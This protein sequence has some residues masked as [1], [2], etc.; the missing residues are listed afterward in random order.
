[1]AATVQVKPLCLTRRKKV[2]AWLPDRRNA[3]ELPRDLDWAGLIGVS[4]PNGFVTISFVKNYH[5]PRGAWPT[6]GPVTT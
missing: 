1:M 6:S 3:K 2:Q 4:R 5:A